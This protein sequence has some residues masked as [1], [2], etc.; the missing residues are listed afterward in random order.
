[1]SQKFPL[2]GKRALVTG[3]SKRLG[4][5]V[6]LALAAEGVH[7]AVHYRNSEAEARQL[8]A[9]ICKHGV[10]SW[11]FQADLQQT[12]QTDTL[13]SSAQNEAG[14]IDILVNNAA[15]F[16][17]DTLSS[18]TESSIESNIRINAIAPMLLS[19]RF[20]EQ[21]RDGAILNF[22]DARAVDYDKEH[23]SYHL[24][25]RMLYSLTRMMAIEYAPRVRV[26]AVAPG[27]VFPPEGKDE[28]YLKELAHTNPLG[29]HGTAQDVTDAALFLI[30][31]DFITG[32]VIFVD[33][34]R[35]LKGSVY[36]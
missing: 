18:L 33:G 24:S 22:L 8:S 6:S 29:N 19:K 32:Q 4:R 31:S 14:S 11:L 13:F 20:A 5:A 9:E 1:M 21:N 30:K 28:G 15:I 16:P 25:K 10:E 27:L 26:N 12:Q 34:G 36:G 7:I 23:V 3:A 35:H 17:A 2:A